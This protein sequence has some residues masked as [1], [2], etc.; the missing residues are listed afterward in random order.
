MVTA[1]NRF[2]GADELGLRQAAYAMTVDGTHKWQ[3]NTYS[4]EWAIAGTQ[5][6]GAEAAILGAQRSSFR[7]FQRPDADHLSIDGHEHFT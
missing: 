5:I 2:D 4:L 1:L 3:R 6:R 7:Y